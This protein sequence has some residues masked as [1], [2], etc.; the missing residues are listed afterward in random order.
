VRDHD[1]LVA[2]SGRLDA[3]GGGLHHSVASAVR[4]AT[5]T[6]YTG[7]N[8]YHFTGGPCAEMV[9]LANAIGDGGRPTHIVAVGDGQRGVIPPCGRCRQVM[10]DYFPNIEVMLPGGRYVTVESLMP[11]TYRWSES[12]G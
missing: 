5:G 10:V 6:I 1:L 2:A 3:A 8:L 7:V 11:E 12:P 9:A 4:V